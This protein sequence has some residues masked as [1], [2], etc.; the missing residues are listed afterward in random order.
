MSEFMSESPEFLK[1]SEETIK[2]TAEIQDFFI[3]IFRF[4]SNISVTYIFKNKWTVL[5]FV[6]IYSNKI[7]E[8]M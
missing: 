8:L 3:I 1:Y 4:F 2:T 6:I 5:N 7:Y